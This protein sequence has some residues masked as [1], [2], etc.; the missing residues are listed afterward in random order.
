MV[1]KTKTN[2][3]ELIMVLTKNIL[4]LCLIQ[5]CV[6]LSKHLKM[7]KIVKETNVRMDSVKIEKK[8]KKLKKNVNKNINMKEDKFMLKTLVVVL[9]CKIVSHLQI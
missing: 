7:H 3:K 1:K 9:G 5:I 8:E 4:K 2:G 6:W